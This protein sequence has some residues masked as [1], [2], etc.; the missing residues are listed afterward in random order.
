MSDYSIYPKAIDGYAQIPLAVDKLSPVSAEGVNRL[1]S[2]IINI[3]KAIGIA[4]HYSSSF[5]EFSTLTER[6][7]NLEFQ[8]LSF[9]ENISNEIYESLEGFD[10]KDLLISSEKIIIRG[11]GVELK[12]TG[13][14]P[15]P[16]PIDGVLSELP[17]SIV[18]MSSD[19]A[20]V[21]GAPP[22]VGFSTF[23]TFGGEL[24][25][26][27]LA[28]VTSQE[29]TRKGISFVAGPGGLFDP[30]AIPVDFSI[31]V[32][33]SS[34]ESYGGGDINIISGDTTSETQRGG[35][36]N[37][38]AGGCQ[39]LSEGGYI[40]IDGGDS[41]GSGSVYLS[42]GRSLDSG[43][44]GASVTLDSSTSE[45]R[46]GG[47]LYLQAGS[48][49]GTPADPAGDGGSVRLA[50]GSGY[51]GGDLL[52]VSGRA[53]G[54]SAGNV[55]ITAQA[56]TS[57]HHGKIIYT[58][59]SD[60]NG[61]ITLPIRSYRGGFGSSVNITDSDH[62]LLVDASSTDVTVTLP[63][64]SQLVGRTYVIKKIDNIG[65]VTI[66]DV[67]GGGVDGSALDLVTEHE[68]VTVQAF[69]GQWWK[70]S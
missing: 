58:G 40:T 18:V 57:G 16:E 41:S 28:I 67:N 1:R 50:A 5:G 55:Y 70:I 45:V 32:Q 53:D 31:A 51:R 49:Y 8:V 14:F 30:E 61:S 17:K 19:T 69:G 7:D 24:D 52:F 38:G 62:T 33:T 3:E 60:F 11:A 23:M 48:S 46:M 37:L 34:S 6:F 10:L 25:S 66:V 63:D 64:P 20:A 29:L 13:T 44:R 59:R 26:A 65:T 43:T 15:I 21:P 2:G 54:G 4:P 42:A 12:P 47:D 68:Y 39:G 56:N 27:D 9:G 22:G 36:L 35:N